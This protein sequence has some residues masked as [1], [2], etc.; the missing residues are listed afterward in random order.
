[1]KQL[2]MKSIKGAENFHYSLL[3]EIAH[4][5]CGYSCCREHCE[6]EAHGGAKVLACLL[7]IDIG[8]AEERMDCYAGWSSHK[9]C[10]R[11]ERK[12]KSKRR[13]NEATYQKGGKD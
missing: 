6:F 8:D 4:L 7:D 2:K 5:I 13:V 9:A 10:G 1:M 12:K 3:H 11:I